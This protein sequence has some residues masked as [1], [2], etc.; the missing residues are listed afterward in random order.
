MHHSVV[1]RI[2]LWQPDGTDSQA[3]VVHN[4]LQDGQVPPASV[5]PVIQVGGMVLYQQSLVQLL[6]EMFVFLVVAHVSTHFRQ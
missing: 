1:E 5:V 4:L 3:A 6:W 2:I